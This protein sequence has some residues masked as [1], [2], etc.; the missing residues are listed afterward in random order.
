MGNAKKIDGRFIHMVFFWL[1]ESTD[2]DE[3][4]KITEGFVTQ[5]DEVNSY[6]I[7]KPAGT[8]REVVDNSYQVSLVVTF[9]SK[10][11]QNVY[12]DHAVHVQYVVDNK[13]KWNR[14]QVYDSWGEVYA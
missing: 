7:G 4:I 5:I 9:N 12:Q 8:P 10:E 13:D 14:V 6:Y 1:K 11:E 2:V 3:F